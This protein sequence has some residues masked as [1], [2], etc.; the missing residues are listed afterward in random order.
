MFSRPSARHFLSFRRSGARLMTCLATNLK[1][2]NHISFLVCPSTFVVLPTARPDRHVITR[3]VTFK[4]NVLRQDHNSLPPR[5]SGFEARGMMGFTGT[6]WAASSA[7]VAALVLS[8]CTLPCSA[9]VD[10]GKAKV[11]KLKKF[12]LTPTSCTFTCLFAAH[13]A[14]GRSAPMG[15]AHAT[16]RR[17]PHSSSVADTQSSDAFVPPPFK[18]SR[19]HQVGSSS[20]SSSGSR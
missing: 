15:V 5:R 6:R 10:I 1:P 3:E 12:F 7:L 4:V 20:G 11:G 2:T 8:Q 9:D 18:T 16:T 13:T 17:Q 19:V 14:V